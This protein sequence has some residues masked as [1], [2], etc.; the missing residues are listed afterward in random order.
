MNKPA[1]TAPD[2]G[3][4]TIADDAIA[5]HAVFTELFKHALACDQT[6]VTNMLISDAQSQLRKAG[7]AT[8]HH[9]HTHEEAIDP[10][11]GVQPVCN[12]FH[13]TYMK[14]LYDFAA[15]MDSVQEGDKTL[16]D[17]M[18]IFGFTDHGKPRIHSA[19]DMPV[20]TFGSGNGRMKTGMHINRPGDTICRVGFT[21]L[22]AMGVPGASYG[23]ASNRVTTPITEIL[24]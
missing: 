7:D 2:G 17:R 4:L 20:I 1:D 5:R 14:A 9:T 15:A 24:A 21:V 13:R 18:I 8:S 11:T 10:A 3:P 23:V 12:W 6:R 22:Q 19:L 16:L